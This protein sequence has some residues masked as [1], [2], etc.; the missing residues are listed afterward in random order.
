MKIRYVYEAPDARGSGRDWSVAYSTPD[1][2]NT[3]AA[4]DLL[5]T[6]WNRACGDDDSPLS[7]YAYQPMKFIR[8]VLEQL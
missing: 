5:N 6:T 7:I 2:N 3:P 1:L 8:A 4:I